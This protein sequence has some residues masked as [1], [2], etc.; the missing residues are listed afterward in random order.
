MI[1][2]ILFVVI[3]AVD[4]LPK[5]VLESFGGASATAVLMTKNMGPTT[6]K[7]AQR[8]ISFAGSQSPTLVAENGSAVAVLNGTFDQISVPNGELITE[9]DHFTA[10]ISGT[11][12]S[13]I[14]FNQSQAKYITIPKNP[15]VCNLM[16][17]AIP[18]E[19]S[20]LL[21]T[22]VPSLTGRQPRN[23]LVVSRLNFKKRGPDA[24]VSKQIKVPFDYSN[25]QFVPGA[26]A[27]LKIET[28]G[29]QIYYRVDINSL[30]LTRLKN[31]PAKN[32]LEWGHLSG[33]GKKLK[34]LSPPVFW[35]G[36]IYGKGSTT[37][38]AKSQA[39]VWDGKTL[40]LTEPWA[41]VGASINGKFAW[42]MN[43]ETGASWVIRHS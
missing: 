14:V 6:N 19:D 10:L 38:G 9:N 40:N 12:A 29:K 13:P 30:K 43:R 3:S 17:R 8:M 34:Y 23:L 26:G 41:I 22:G 11:A 1:S 31:A 42:L 21:V 20:V 18:S 4:E 32:P 5:D 28:T 36:R 37:Y 35:D 27:I 39:Y 16:P 7:V 25:P 24:N 33:P 2:C 15:L